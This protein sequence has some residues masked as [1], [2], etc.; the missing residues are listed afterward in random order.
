MST[1]A[2]QPPRPAIWRARLDR[3]VHFD[4]TRMSRKDRARW[5]SAVSMADL[6]ELVIAWLHGEVVQTPGHCGPPDDETYPLIPDLE[7]INRGGFIT[8][9]SQLAETEGGYAWNTWVSGFADD[10][11]LK[12]LRRAVKGTPLT[13]EA[14]RGKTHGCYRKW[15][16]LPRCPRN[17]CTDFWADKCPKAAAAL[18][19]TWWVHIEDP[20]PGRNDLL[21]PA[22]TTALKR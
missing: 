2:V 7:V 17:E 1:Q 9:N 8:D 22:L 13:L 21:W 4:P 15:W 20:E 16:H 18:W 5:R 11:T 12:R 19:E 6:G 14:C 3:L 10:A